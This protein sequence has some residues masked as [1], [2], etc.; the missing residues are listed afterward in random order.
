MLAIG[1]TLISQEVMKVAF[2]CD[3]N[4][5]KGACCVAGD[6]GAPLEEA[7][8]ELL[9][10]VYEK[11][12]PYLT[13][14]GIRTIEKNGNYV[15]DKEDREFVTPLIIRSDKEKNKL[16]KSKD[17]NENARAELKECAYTIFENGIALCGIE[18]AFNEGKIDF[19][20][21]ISCHLYPIRITK[22]N[23]YDSLNYN[24]WDVCSPACELGKQT[25]IPIFEFVSSAL[26]RKYGAAWLA[27]LRL[28]SSLLV[29]QKQGLR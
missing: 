20:K 14:E 3:L 2:T 13:E 27:E 23:G 21:P 5:C 25:R 28:A 24:R 22:K 10:K 6:S 7:E 1:N 29:K 19:H 8:L 11:V 18:K 15:Y 12:K 9:D 26:T 17:K 4:R 16:R